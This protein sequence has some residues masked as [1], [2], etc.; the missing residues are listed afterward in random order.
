MSSCCAPCGG[1]SDRAAAPPRSVTATTSN[2]RV[3]GLVD[4]PGGVFAMG[5]EG[6]RA[7]P[8]DGEGPV[9]DVEVAPFRIA[10]TTVT[11]Q[12]FAT[13]IKATGYVTEAEHSGWSFVFHALVTDPAA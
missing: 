8:G 7:N 2:P 11:N 4:V 1:P 13:F 6:P 9:R 3:R 10:P 5:Y 12:Q